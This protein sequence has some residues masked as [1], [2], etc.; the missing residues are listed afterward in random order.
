M[1]RGVI[2]WRVIGWSLAGL[3]CL[4]TLGVAALVGNSS[5]SKL[6]EGAGVLVESSWVPEGRGFVVAGIVL[7]AVLIL[8]AE[9]ACALMA[10]GPSSRGSAVLEGSSAT[11]G[12]RASAG[13]SRAGVP[14][15]AGC[16]S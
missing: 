12:P 7:V 8:A 1:G 10:H 2:R 5:G 13:P 15:P 16:V 9:W 3:S 14:G 11:G 4:L 6:A